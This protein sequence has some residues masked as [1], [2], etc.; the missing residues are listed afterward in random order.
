MALA[1]MAFWQGE[2]KNC[3]KNQV[4]TTTG[5]TQGK[6]AWKCWE[7]P[8]GK[9]NNIHFNSFSFKLSKFAQNLKHLYFKNQ[10]GDA[11]E[12]T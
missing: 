12:R 5:T 1:S 8:L 6:P 10:P 4:H 7:I 2:P 9:Y 11:W 3:R